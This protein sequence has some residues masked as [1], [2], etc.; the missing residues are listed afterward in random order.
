MPVV[1]VYEDVLSQALGG[2]DEHSFDALCFEFGLELDDVTSDFEIACKERGKLAAEGLSKR[3][4]YKVD[5][6]ANR[7]DLLCVEG[8]VRALSIFKG[9]LKTPVYQLSQKA[10][11]ANMRM[12]VHASVAQIRPFVVCAVLRGVTFNQDRYQSFIDLQDKLHMNICRKRTLCAIG[13]HDLST[14]TPPFTYEALPPK[15]IKFVPLNQTEE[16][17]GNR[18]MEAFAAHQQLKA[19][20]PIIK[21]SPVYPVIFDSKRTVLSVPPIINGEHSKIRLETK[22]V[23]IEMTAT[24]LTK[25][26]ITLNTVVAMFSEYCEKPFTVEP[27]EVV[28]ADDY[29][30]NTFTQPGQKIIYPNLENR[31]MESKIDRLKSSLSLN[32]LT[33]EEVR[34]LLKKM[35]VPCELDAKDKNIL[36]VEVPITR[37]DI[38]H[39][40]DLVEDIAI[41]FGYNNLHLEVPMTFAGAAEQPV[42][43]LTDLIRVEMAN[44]GFTEALNWALLSR[45][46][47]FVK[48]RREEKPEDL[49]RL[50]SRP[51][52]YA[53]TLLSVSVKD[54]KT[55]EFEIVRTSLLPG[56][57]KTLACNKAQ[58]VPIRIFEAGDVVIQEPTREV[59]SR[60]VRRVAALY[61]STKSAFSVLHGALDQLMYSLGFEPEHEHAEGS[62]RGTYKLVPSEDP[63]FLKGMQA[64]VMVQDIAI[65]VIGELHP[66]VLGREGFDINLATSAFEVNVEP[67]LEWL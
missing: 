48:M 60:N 39:E 16:M 9:T 65:G 57:L 30:G 14:L 38:M 29:P 24:D 25:A 34:D 21:D 36:Q 45:K 53:E 47:N 62:K 15:D 50:V 12:T 55:K 18:L 4:I 58:E 26:N 23:F 66:E 43:H 46:E 19:Y 33:P 6:P 20:L 51:H 11:V 28:Y 7:Y 61:S 37:S 56:I 35:S 8:V 3:V 32:H 13:T 22:D 40:C 44:A 31:P 54:P 59:G 49:W 67:F 17:D 41:S 64:H 10:P 1:G 5:I 2:I 63:A 42:N 27:V 52:E